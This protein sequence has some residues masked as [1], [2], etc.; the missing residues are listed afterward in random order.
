MAKDFS[1]QFGGREVAR[2]EIPSWAGLQLAFAGGIRLEVLEP[3]QDPRDDFLQRF[4]E[5][6]GPSP[7]HATFKVEDIRGALARLKELGIEPVKVDLS[8]PGWQEAFLHPALG[9]GTVVQLAQQGGTWSAERAPEPE[10]EG[11]VRAE[12]LG[13]E[14]AANLEAAKAV[15]GDVLGGTPTQVGPGI[16]Y[17]WPGGGSLVVN[18]AEE[19]ARPRVRALVFRQSEG[20]EVDLDA[21]ED[22]LYDS[23]ATLLKLGPHGA[24]PR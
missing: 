10:P 11:A 19:G 20:S 13:A 23:P 22:Q 17:S 5:H 16:A 21:G 15:F 1:R 9:L 6:S 18:P 7:H 3:V 2:F 14:L 8:H 12:F 24:W 4:L